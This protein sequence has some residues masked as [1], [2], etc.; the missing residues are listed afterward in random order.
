MQKSL[1]ENMLLGIQNYPLFLIKLNEMLT[2]NAAEVNLFSLQLTPVLAM[3][4]RICSLVVCAVFDIIYFCIYK[5]H[6]L[7]YFDLYMF[8]S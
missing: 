4:N 6:L 7:I 8:C 5:F 3:K 1:L 2:L